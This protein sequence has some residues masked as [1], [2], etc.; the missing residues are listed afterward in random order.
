MLSGADLRTHSE[1]EGRNL[2]ARHLGQR[3]LIVSDDA[4]NRDCGGLP[5]SLEVMGAHLNGSH[6]QPEKW[7]DA[8]V[9]LRG[10]RSLRRKGDRLFARL[11]ISYESLDASEQQIFLDAACFFL[12]QAVE[13]AKR[14]WLG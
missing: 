8:L 1:N 14:V 12:G 10:A 6:N 2:L 4:D 9:K 3:A 11:R 5:L 7:W 13:T